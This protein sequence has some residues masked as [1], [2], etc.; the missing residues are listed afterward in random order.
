MVSRVKFYESLYS[1]YVFFFF[2]TSIHF[3]VLHCST[4]FRSWVLS[5]AHLTPLP[6]ESCLKGV[7]NISLFLLIV[8]N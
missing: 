5:Y 2:F 4:Q 8:Q 6:L 1:I 7:F 3:Y